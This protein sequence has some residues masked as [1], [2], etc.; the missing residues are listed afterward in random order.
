MADQPRQAPQAVAVPRSRPPEGVRK[1]MGL[2]ALGDHAGSRHIIP[3]STSRR[4]RAT[5]ARSV[6]LRPSDGTHAFKDDS[7]AAGRYPVAMR[8][9][10]SARR[11]QPTPGS[12]VLGYGAMRTCVGRVEGESWRALP[13]VDPRLRASASALPLRTTRSSTVAS[14]HVDCPMQDWLKT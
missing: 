11:D 9:T 2:S 4:S 13:A 3:G 5:T 7:G 10:G 1:R 14:R 12:P 8:P 6:R